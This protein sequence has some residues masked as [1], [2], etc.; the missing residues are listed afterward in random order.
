MLSYIW[1]IAK[2]ILG[3]FILYGIY[4]HNWSV[5]SYIESNVEKVQKF[6]GDLNNSFELTRDLVASEVMTD[7][8]K[9]AIYILATGVDEDKKEIAALKEQLEVVQTENVQMKVALESAIVPEASVK[10]AAMNHVVTPAK[11]TLV[12]VKDKAADLWNTYE[13]QPQK[14]KGWFSNVL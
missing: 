4:Q 12:S 3:L 6:T 9:K 7:S 10:E 2:V 13:F 5:D 1:G 8:T 11:D 14:V